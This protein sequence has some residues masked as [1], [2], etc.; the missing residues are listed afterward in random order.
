MG[1]TLANGN[2]YGGVQSARAVHGLTLAET[3]YEPGFVVP[4]HDHIHPFFCLNI[5]GSFLERFENRPW[6]A[7][8][9]TVFFHPSGAD[10]GEEFGGDGGRVFNIQLGRAWLDRIRQYGLIPPQRQIS[11]SGGTMARL[12]FQMLREYR[13]GDTASDLALDGLAMALLAHVVREDRNAPPKGKGARPAWLDRVEALLRARVGEPMDISS[14]AQE[15]GVHPT[16]LSRVFRRHYGCS[17]GQY[18]RR[19]RIERACS[20]LAQSRKPLS[21]I[22]LAT[23][24]ADQSHFTRHFKRATG[25]TPGAYR[26]L[27]R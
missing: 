18:L 1:N 19:L 7:N 22:A 8:P 27:L 9:S 13:I 16:H 21:T 4:L 11:V 25:V 20:L 6:R 5:R 14:I 23:G 3:G 12:A 10:H 24:Y 17:P 26:D 2:F 15:V